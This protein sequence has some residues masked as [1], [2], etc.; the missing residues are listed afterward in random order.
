MD[1]NA[2]LESM[3][4]AVREYWA[5]TDSGPVNPAADALAEYFDALDGWIS[6]GGFLPDAWRAGKDY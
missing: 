3:R 1:P 6:K 2:A 5:S 4:A